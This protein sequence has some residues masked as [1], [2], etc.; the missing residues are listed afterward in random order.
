MR[1]LALV[2]LLPVATAAAEPAPPPPPLAAAHGDLDGDGRPDELR[3]EP[4]GHVRALSADGKPL[5]HV[6]L[7]A[8]AAD[9]HD[10]TIEV[11]TVEKRQVA[12]VRAKLRG[13]QSIDA[14]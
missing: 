4:D 5:G 3:L 2:V 7:T 11:L 8:P 10:A 12:H 6:A 9:L 14:V 13:A 1:P